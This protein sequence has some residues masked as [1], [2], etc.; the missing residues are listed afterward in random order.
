MM[1]IKS[2]IIY[3]TILLIAGNCNKE[4][5]NRDI[6]ISKYQNIYGK[7]KTIYIQGGKGFRMEPDFQLLQ[8]EK[9]DKFRIIEDT[10]ICQGKILINKQTEDTLIINLKPE[11]GSHVLSLACSKLV[12]I[13]E[14]T[15]ILDESVDCA[16]AYKYIFL[17]N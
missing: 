12:I 14:D 16:D 4:E 8:F 1:D 11:K 5:E 3:I 2:I 15:L 17:R 9:I 7:W 6:F 13:N 10:I